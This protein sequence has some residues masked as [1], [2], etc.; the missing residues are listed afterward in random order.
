MEKIN[1][2]TISPIEKHENNKRILLIKD[3]LTR[4]IN[5]LG[6]YIYILM[7]QPDN[8]KNAIKAWDN[9]ENIAYKPITDKKALERIINILIKI[10]SKNPE[11]VIVDNKKLMKLL[12]K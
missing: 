1:I 11:I 9:L 7:Q 10:S 5:E 2:E 3:V 6:M 12:D 4:E 8:K